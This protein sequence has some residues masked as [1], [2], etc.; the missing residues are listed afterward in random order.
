MYM[1][2]PGCPGAIQKQ[3]DALKVGLRVDSRFSG[4]EMN[5]KSAKYG[6]WGLGPESDLGLARYA[7]F[8]DVGAENCLTRCVARLLSVPE[9]G[10]RGC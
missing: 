5:L 2:V 3:S 7:N 9:L 6:Q 4:Q 1:D 10:F 8:W